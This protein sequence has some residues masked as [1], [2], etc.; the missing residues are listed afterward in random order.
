MFQMNNYIYL[1][2][3]TGTP[4][5]HAPIQCYIGYK[6]VFSWTPNDFQ[7]IFKESADIRNSSIF[8]YTKYSVSLKKTNVGSVFILNMAAY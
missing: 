3:Y 4:I 6:A 8:F 5:Q 7:K 2:I 1:Y